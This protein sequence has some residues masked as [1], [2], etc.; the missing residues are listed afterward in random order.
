MV[1]DTVGSG[2]TKQYGWHESNQSKHELCGDLKAWLRNMRGTLYDAILIDECSTFI[3]MDNGKLDH[4]EGKRSDCV[5][6]AGLTVQAS[7]FLGEPPKKIPEPLT[8]WRAQREKERKA[9]RVW[10]N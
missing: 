8:G 5:I 7:I 4:E 2:L 6:A 1:P 3:R 9:K 10:A